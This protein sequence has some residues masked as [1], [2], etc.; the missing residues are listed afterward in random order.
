MV[1]K[2]HGCQAGFTEQV[3]SSAASPPLSFQG[4]FTHSIDSKGRVSLPADFRHILSQIGDDAV[5]LTNYIS[6]G[7]RCLEG[8]P[9]SAWKEFEAKLKSKSRFSA[10]LQRLENFYL[11]R[12]ARCP[13]DKS[14]RILIPEYLRRYA[15]LT[16]EVTFTAS[17]HGFRVWDSRV[18]DLIFSNTEKDLMEDPELFADVDI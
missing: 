4:N 2:K 7:S 12:A 10:K 17:I 1:E 9:E 8:F 3:I 6:E 18:W 13:L 14:G 15:S 5:V 16:K 11:A